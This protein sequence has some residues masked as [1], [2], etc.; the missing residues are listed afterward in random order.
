MDIQVYAD[1]FSAEAE[2]EVINVTLRNV[3]LSLF[4]GQFNP[5]DVLEAI[6]AND[7]YSDITDY[8]S[9]SGEDK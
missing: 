8:V 6:T 5:R 7:G 2:N 3:D 9:D 1:S 4:I